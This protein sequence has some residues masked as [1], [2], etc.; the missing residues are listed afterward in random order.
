MVDYTPGFATLRAGAIHGIARATADGTTVLA[1]FPLSASD[2]DLED[3]DRAVGKAEVIGVQAATCR[4]QISGLTDPNTA[5]TFKA[6]V[7]GLPTS[8][9]VV[10]LE[11][12]TQAVEAARTAL[13]SAGQGGGP[14]LYVR[15]VADPQEPAELRLLAQQGQYLITRIENNRP[16]ADASLRRRLS[17]RLRVSRPSVA[18]PAR[19]RLGGR[20]SAVRR[21]SSAGPLLSQYSG[22]LM[23]IAGREIRT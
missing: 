11:G 3:L 12:E 20:S 4:L 15:E 16:L 13:E 23:I 1:L 14:S 7:I 8:R 10:R 6:I 5:G 22:P 9:L 18:E 19:E 17:S 21:K 2:R